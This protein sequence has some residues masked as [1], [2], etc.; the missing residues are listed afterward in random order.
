MFKF[1][2]FA[3]LIAAMISPANAR[4]G[5]QY[6]DY[7]ETDSICS[8]SN[9]PFCDFKWWSHDLVVDECTLEEDTFCGESV[10]NV[11]CNAHTGKT[12]LSELES[13]TGFGW[14]S[15]MYTNMTHNDDIDK[16][17]VTLI[18]FQ[19][20]ILCPNYDIADY[21]I[22]AVIAIFAVCG[23]GTIVY[24]LSSPCQC[25]PNRVTPYIPRE[26]ELEPANVPVQRGILSRGDS[27]NSFETLASS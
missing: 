13:V 1:V 27:C 18:C 8:L 23:L 7:D 3:I 21:I 11:Q 6:D 22:I 15:C 14:R 24:V 9:G 17:N 16:I 10:F 25:C 19:K 12:N 26:V 4:P 2:I 5:G 20:N